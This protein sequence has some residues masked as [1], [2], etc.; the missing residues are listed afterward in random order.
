[1]SLTTY[2][3]LKAAV[4][5]WLLR[6]DL[7][8]V[9]PSFISLA[10]ADMNRTLR[11]WRMEASVFASMSDQ[12]SPLPADFIEVARVTGPNSER[13]ELASRGDMQDMRSRSSDTSGTPTSYALTSGKLEL[14]PTPSASMQITL[15]YVARPPALSDSKATNWVMTYHPDIYLYG[16]LMQSAPYLKDDER[17]SIWGGM[18]QKALQEANTASQQAR[19][20]GTNPR[21]KIRSY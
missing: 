8:S 21:V 4:A 14:Y 12:F 20:A 10:E 2:T 11:H 5:D 15:E 6:D 9:I 19:F 16:T 3:E 18:Y 17:V 7:T 13:I 1:M